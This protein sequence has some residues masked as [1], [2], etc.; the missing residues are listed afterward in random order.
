MKRDVDYDGEILVD[1]SA[2]DLP[3]YSEVRVCRFTAPKHGLAR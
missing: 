3:I 2:T 1:K